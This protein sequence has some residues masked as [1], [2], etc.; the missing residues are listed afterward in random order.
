MVNLNDT[1][2]SDPSKY[3]LIGDSVLSYRFAIPY[4]E[5]LFVGDILKITDREKDLTFLAKV[6]DLLHE[7]N[8]EDEKWDRRPHT[9]QFYGLSEDVYLV[10]EALPLGFVDG[11]GVFRRPRTV[12]TKFSRVELPEARDFAFLQQVMG[13]IQVGVMKTGQGVLR[14]VRVALH[15]RVM[16]QHMGVFATTG[17]GKSNFMKVFCAS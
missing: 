17:M 3:R 5:T 8:F 16:P 15:S 12:P 6:T 9:E 11:R 1:D 2:L 13:D 14:D 7:S 4:Q 10:V